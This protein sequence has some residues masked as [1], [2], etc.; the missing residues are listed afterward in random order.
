MRLLPQKHFLH[1]S[2]LT[3]NCRRRGRSSRWPARAL[4]RRRTSNS[5]QGGDRDADLWLARIGSGKG[6]NLG[7][8]SYNKVTIVDGVDQPR[9]DGDR[10]D[11]EVWW[12]RWRPRENE[13]QG[14]CWSIVRKKYRGDESTD[15]REEQLLVMIKDDI[16]NGDNDRDRERDRGQQGWTEDEVVILWREDA[17]AVEKR[18]SQ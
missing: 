9:R 16:V 5:N 6:F 12:R 8:N 17:G 14:W 2:E 15:H 3:K 10:G 11:V 4:Q 1:W 13:Y 7:I 18:W